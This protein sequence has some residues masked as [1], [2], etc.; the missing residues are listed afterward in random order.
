M[1]KKINNFKNTLFNLNK[2][3]YTT[4]SSPI[5]LPEA[6][7]DLDSTNVSTFIQNQSSVI[8]KPFKNNEILFCKVVNKTLKHETQLCRLFKLETNGIFRTKGVDIF[9]EHI[10]HKSNLYLNVSFDVGDRKID[11]RRPSL[12][13][14]ISLKEQQAVSSHFSIITLVPLLLEIGK[15]SKVLECGTGS[16]SMS[17]FLSERIGSEGC[18][19]TFDISKIKAQMGKRAFMEWKYTHDLSSDE[20]WP[21]NVKFGFM[22][23]NNDNRW[24]DQMGEFYDAIYLDMSELDKGI[25]Q[26][27]KMLKPDGVLVVNGMHLTQIFKCLNVI[28]QKNLG[29]ER[30]LI[31][32]P[33]NRL[34]ELRKIKG[35]N[36]PLDWTARLEDRFGEKKKRGGLFF[37][38]W[39]GFLAK[40]RKIK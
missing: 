14:F 2:Q 23:F 6:D 25:Q 15:G 37:N 32:E 26:A 16:G 8:A 18:L 13:E 29:L 1:L 20:K 10:I 5:D 24:C 28:E 35:S 38:Y 11:F 19:H 27:Y 4:Y 12:Y 3:F 30:E 39:Q 9:H 34:W 36:D 31:I 7:I 21:A 33:S 22:D 17:L 40:F